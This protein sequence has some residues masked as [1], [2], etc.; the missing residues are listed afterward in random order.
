MRKTMFGLIVV[1]IALFGVSLASPAPDKVTLCHVTAGDGS[2]HVIVV[3][4]NALAAHVGHG[5]QPIEGVK[6]AACT[7]ETESSED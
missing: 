4:L 2:G 1:G 5:D 6:G 3:A 7:I